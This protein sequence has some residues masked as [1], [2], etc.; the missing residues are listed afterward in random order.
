[1]KP[2]HLTGLTAKIANRIGTLVYRN[3]PGHIEAAALAVM[4]SMTGCRYSV[5]RPVRPHSDPNALCYEP[6]LVQRNFVLINQAPSLAEDTCSIAEVVM[7]DAGDDNVARLHMTNGLAAW[8]QSTHN[9]GWMLLMPSTTLA[10]L[11]RLDP[12]EV[13]KA[14]REAK[15]L[16]ALNRSKHHPTAHYP[17]LIPQAKDMETIIRASP[18]TILA[19]IQHRELKAHLSEEN[20]GGHI[21][22]SAVF[23]PAGGTVTNTRPEVLSAP[24]ELNRQL[25]ALSKMRG[26]YLKPVL[27]QWDR[28]AE[29]TFGMFDIDLRLRD[30]DRPYLP[31]WVELGEQVIDIAALLAI[32]DNPHTPIISVVNVN[33]AI[34]ITTRGYRAYVRL[35]A[36]KSPDILKP[37]K[38]TQ[39][40]RKACKKIG[41]KRPLQTPSPPTP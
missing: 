36:H 24:F 38:A 2:Y 10:E 15:V 26:D 23:V 5:A 20:V 41:L 9:P 16:D 8:K 39:V 13:R 22:Y 18:P 6:R 27:V 35:M 4:S 33:A 29:A 3:S 14:S 31:D 21:G 19:A 25:S 7:R 37:S 17:H 11:A 28:M 12:R 1:M 32:G 30:M 40:L 34:R